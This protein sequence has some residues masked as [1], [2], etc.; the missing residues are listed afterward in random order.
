MIKDNTKSK[1]KYRM[2]GKLCKSQKSTCPKSHRQKKSKDIHAKQSG[3]LGFAM[4]CRAVVNGKRRVQCCQQ[5]LHERFHTWQEQ[6]LFELLFR[7]MLKF[8]SW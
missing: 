4:R 1:S 5:R 8:Y 3:C 2:P 6:G 7:K